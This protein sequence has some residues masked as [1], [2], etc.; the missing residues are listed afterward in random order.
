MSMHIVATINW[1]SPS[2]DELTNCFMMLTKVM[3]LATFQRGLGVAPV[4]MQ[5]ISTGT[6]IRQSSYQ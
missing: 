2:S 3:L 6:C 1:S 5:Q 4:T